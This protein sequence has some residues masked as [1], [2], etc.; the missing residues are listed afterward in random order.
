M[1][2]LAVHNPDWDF[3]SKSQ[4]F[5]PVHSLIRKLTASHHSS[6]PSKDASALQR[7]YLLDSEKGTYWNG[8]CDNKNILLFFYLDIHEKHLC[9]LSKMNL[10]LLLFFFFFVGC[11]FI[12]TSPFL[13]LMFLS[14]HIYLVFWFVSYRLSSSKWLLRVT[15]STVS[16]AEH[17]P[18]F[19]CIW[20]F[21]SLQENIC[22]CSMFQKLD[23]KDLSK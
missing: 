1:A 14:M 15:V 10:R 13:A 17:T 7:N 6:V 3:S 5:F 8:T 18:I 2:F 9:L 20:S 23:R 22:M 4:N 16:L 11:V 21:S 12:S 19:F